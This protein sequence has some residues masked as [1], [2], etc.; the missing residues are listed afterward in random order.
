M[1]R[2][3]N[4]ENKKIR[5]DK[6]YFLEEEIPF[7]GIFSGVHTSEVYENG[8]KIK[9]LEYYTTGI[10]KK[11][12]IYSYNKIV[13]EIDYFQNGK[14]NVKINN[15]TNI[16]EEY[17]EQGNLFR[18]LDKDKYLQNKNGGIMIIMGILFIFFILQFIYE[19]F[20]I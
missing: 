8:I 5:E 16:V 2:I 11:E 10:I 9:E 14:I 20:L 19:V 3:E 6:I 12:R 15:E 7:T 1:N 17:D 4:I 18:K 13:E